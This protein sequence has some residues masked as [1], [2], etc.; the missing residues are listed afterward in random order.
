MTTTRNRLV[1]PGLLLVA[2][3]TGV[4]GSLGAPIIPEIAREEDVPLRT[5]QWS[6]TAGLLVSAV[7]T[8]VVGRLGAGRRRKPTILV[9]LGVVAVGTLLAALPLGIGALIAGRALQGTGFALTPLAFAVARD[10]LPVERQRSAIAAISVASIVS[11][12]LGFP[13]TAVTAELAGLKGAFWLGFVLTLVALG[14]A[15]LTVPP[16]AEPV[17]T[18]IDWPGAAL[19]GAGTFLL[20]LAISQADHWGYLAPV[21][22][23]A[24]LGGFALLGCCAWWLRRATYPLVDLSL[25]AHPGVAGAHV[26]ALVAGCAMYMVFALV[27]VLLQTPDGAGFGLGLSVAVAG[28]M[29]VPYA[30]ASVVGNQL[31]LRFGPAIGA[32]LLLPFGCLVYAVA[33]LVFLLAP[34]S[35]GMVLVL[36]VVSG[37]GSGLTF[38]SIP[39]L[40]LRFV[41]AAETGSA[42]S[43]NLV[44][45]FLGFSLGSALSL[46]ALQGFADDDGHPT[47]LGYRMGAA[48]GVAISLVAALACG[49]LARAATRRARAAVPAAP[50]AAVGSE[51]PA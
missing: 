11:A 17:V 37:L 49:L 10:A 43:F 6:L 4:I 21:T 30:V 7:A 15:L 47:E 35:L 32:D 8:P 16:S 42:M 33:N 31:A 51:F 13:V 36:M 5:A 20:L 1:L 14:V 27:M 18:R 46:A 45:R 22:V 2:M 44:M 25:A 12:G 50:V 19:L 26:A 24:V 40:M 38:N 28:S 23:A 9:V 39:W 48:W 29:M 34:A 41:P 3:V